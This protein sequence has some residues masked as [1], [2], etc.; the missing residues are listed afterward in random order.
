MVVFD[1]DKKCSIIDSIYKK[2]DK[3][4]GTKQNLPAIVRH[5]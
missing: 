5:S 4:D 1:V 2:E 3:V